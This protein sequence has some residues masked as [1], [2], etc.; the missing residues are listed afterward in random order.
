[1]LHHP[2]T[3]TAEPS[4]S[5]PV[6]AH[7][8]NRVPSTPPA[9]SSELSPPAARCSVFRPGMASLVT[10]KR[11]KEELRRRGLPMYGDKSVLLERCRE[12]G[13][14]VLHRKNLTVPRGAWIPRPP[15]LVSCG[16][17][18]FP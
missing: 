7:F 3:D 2:T 18:C 16:R 13:A 1:M 9:T 17:M 11:L 4:Q 10:V 8:P 5:D 15:L 14:Y 12:N 6:T